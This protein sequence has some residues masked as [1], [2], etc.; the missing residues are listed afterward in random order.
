MIELLDYE[1]MR[2]ALVAA[3]FTGLAAPAIGT[4]LV[5]RRLAL[6]GDG[7][8]HVALTG[9][10]LGLLTGIAP[11]VTAVVVAALGAVV[12]E[13]LRMY[14]R[15][16]ADVALAMLFYGGIAGGVLL[17]NLADESANSLNGYLFGAITTVSNGDLVLVG[18]L[19]LLVVVLSL[20]LSPQLFAVCQDEEHAKVSG[21]PVRLYSI[22]IAV[23]AAVTITVAMRTVGLLLVSALMVVPVAAS[24]QLTRSFRTTHL[25]AMAIGLVAA[26]GGLVTSYEINTQPGPTIVMIALAIFVI[27]SLT[28]MVVSR[29]RARRHRI[30]SL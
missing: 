16:S 15:T 20:G 29:G 6:L 13:L 14:G 28:A 24:Q 2:R 30:G 25:A 12:I 23:L 18:V 3:V 22:L 17:T 21:V 27:A 1:F 11:T 7:L 9:V 4:F 8:G 26:V 5:Q 19:G 10:A